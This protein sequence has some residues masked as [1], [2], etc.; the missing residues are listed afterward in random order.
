MLFERW[1]GRWNCLEACESNEAKLC[2]LALFE[3]CGR[4]LRGAIDCGNMFITKLTNKTIGYN[5]KC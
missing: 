4:R 2:I 3:E 5:V 1:F